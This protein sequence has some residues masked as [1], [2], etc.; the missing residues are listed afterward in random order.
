MAGLRAPPYF[1]SYD[2]YERL[3][4]ALVGNGTLPDR[5][6]LFRDIQLSS[7]YSTI[8]VRAADVP[9]TRPRRAP[10]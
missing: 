7:R 3:L 4:T 1:T 5:R 2:V 6:T 9:V 8:E 10:C